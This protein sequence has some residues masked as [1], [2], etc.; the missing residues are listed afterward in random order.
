[1]KKLKKCMVLSLTAIVMI[2]SMIPVSAAKKKLTVKAVY[3]TSTKIK[4]KTKKRYQ[5]RV[6]IGKK[7]YKKKASKKGNF[8]IT[9][10]KQ[11]AGKK[12]TVK[13]YRKKHK[14][15]KLYAK[16]T[17][18]V[19]KKTAKTTVKNTKSKYPGKED[20]INL[21]QVNK[22]LASGKTMIKG[23]TDLGTGH[24]YYS[25]N[26]TGLKGTAKVGY[27]NDYI[28]IDTDGET[29][30]LKATK[31]ATLYYTVAGEGE[32]SL[33][34]LKEP[35]LESDCLKPGQTTSFTCYDYDAGENGNLH[36]KVKAYK[37][38]KLIAISYFY[39]YLIRPLVLR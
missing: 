39:H 16:K 26:Y 32:K 13:A 1:M 4:G 24:Y 7:T 12:L 30:T 29:V 15:W 20:P 21:E 14:K 5:I 23:Q 6:K 34:Q 9:I 33:L 25:I 28:K 11:K 38:G 17:I 8:T 36:L 35:T 31:G 2:T 10:P 37:N 19:K 3:N 18:T 22:D 27:V